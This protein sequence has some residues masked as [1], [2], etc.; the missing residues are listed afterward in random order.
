MPLDISVK[1]AFLKQTAVCAEFAESDLKKVSEH[2]LLQKYTAGN[3]IFNEKDNPDYF[4]IIFSGMVKIIK[5]EEDGSEIIVSLLNSGDCFGELAI[6][7]NIS[8]NAGAVALHDTELLK[9]EMRKFL[10]MVKKI[11]LFAYNLLKIHLK[12]LK[13]ANEL[14]RY[15]SLCSSEKTILNS[16]FRLGFKFGRVENSSLIIP[17][18]MS[19]QEMSNL[20]GTSRK[21]F[22]VILKNLEEKG[23]LKRQGDSRE[24]MEIRIDNYLRI[25]KLFN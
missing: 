19:H 12:W 14:S 23:I 1:V 21:N 15:L 17:P 9:I 7:D 4:F 11:P 16:L 2:C 3:L 25:E 8:R 13:E 24:K 10:E 22:T 18:V 20:A 5:T 6:I